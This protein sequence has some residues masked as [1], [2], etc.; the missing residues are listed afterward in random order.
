MQRRPRDESPLTAAA[1]ANHTPR[2]SEGSVRIAS[3][4]SRRARGATRRLRLGPRTRER[5]LRQR[6]R[7]SVVDVRETGEKKPSG[8]E[9]SFE[10]GK[11][12]FP[13]FGIRLHVLEPGEPNGL[14]HSESEQEAFLVLA[15]ECTLLVEG[16]ER[17]L[18]AVGLLPQPRGDR[19]HPRGCR[20]RA[21]RDPDG[22]R[23]DGA[24]GGALS[25]VGA[26][27]A[28]RRER[29]GGDIRPAGRRT[30]RRSSSRHGGS[31]PRTGT[32]SPGPSPGL[33][34]AIEGVGSAN[35]PATLGRAIVS[36]CPRVR[37]TYR[38]ARWHA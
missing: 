7:R 30:P 24:L 37:P 18:E 38:L 16:E 3:V 20:R 8:S 26:R 31:G 29:G 22:R 15:G 28:L 33:A 36:E 13:Q 19:T 25:G 4:D 5:W 14:Y 12:E 32:A 1:R 35:R 17:V 27:S 21:V 2:S 9:C 34:Q 6:A 11:F 23:T 10:S